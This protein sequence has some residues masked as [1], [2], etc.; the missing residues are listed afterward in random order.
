MPA[1]LDQGLTEI[2][3]ELWV[4]PPEYADA[5]NHRGLRLGFRRNAESGQWEWLFLVGSEL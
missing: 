3:R 5:P 1:L 2:G 4:A